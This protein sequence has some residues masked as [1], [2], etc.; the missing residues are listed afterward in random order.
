M[1]LTSVR[2][3]LSACA[4]RVLSIPGLVDILALFL[5]K[6]SLFDML[7][8]VAH[9]RRELAF[10]LV[11]VLAN[12]RNVHFLVK[13]WRARRAVAALA[14][15]GDVELMDKIYGAFQC[16]IDEEMVRM[17][18]LG[19]QRDA[20]RWLHAK[21]RGEGDNRQAHEPVYTEEELRAFFS[22]DVLK[23]AAKSGDLEMVRL[24]A[25]LGTPDDSNR[26]ERHASA[27]K[28]AAQHAHLRVIEWLVTRFELP[29]E[30]L[31]DD[32]A[33]TGP[34]DGI[35]AKQRRLECSYC[36]QC[37]GSP[38]SRRARAV[39][40]ECTKWRM[41]FAASCGRLED[42]QWFHYNR[43]EHGCTTNAMDQAAANGHLDVVRW[44]H[45]NRSEGCTVRAMDGAARNGHLLLVQFLHVQRTE[46]CT[47]DAMDGAAA[48]GHLEVVKYLHANR[49]EGCTPRALDAAAGGGHWPV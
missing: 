27:F 36:R 30:W 14:Y 13:R 47:T 46:G 28:I 8:V 26:P 1:P 40:P 35:G 24:V 9:G 7:D 16:L 5:L 22:C 32:E 44:L 38:D 11:D 31:L 37:W 6:P 21:L 25:E 33:H 4:P 23:V 34:Y 29:S 10:F 39:R 45:D 20:L 15:V 42:V 3:V 41:D 43:P 17:A 18:V 12:D 48:N 19:G 2:A 49:S